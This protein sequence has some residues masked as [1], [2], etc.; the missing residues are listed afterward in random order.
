MRLIFMGTPDFADSI[1]ET[2]LDDNTFEVV[3]V[4]SQPP[5]PKGRGH[6]VTLS[7]V[8]EVAQKHNIPVL[9]PVCLKNKEEQELFDSYKADIAVVAAYGLLLPKEILQSP[10]KGCVNVHASLL[11]RFR[12]AAPIQRAILQGDT[13]TG[14]TFMKM[15]EGLDTGDM[16]LCKDIAITPTD[17][18]ATVHDKLKHLANDSIGFWLKEYFKGGL[19]P[20]FQPT[21][22]IT[23]A[24]KLSKTEAEVSFHEDASLIERKVRALSPWPGVWCTLNQERVKL[25]EV[26]VVDKNG[27]CGEIID[28]PLTVACQTKSLNIKVLQKENSKP[29][30]AKDY[31]N[32]LKGH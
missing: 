9:T 27:P 18:A 13:Q 2:L 25:L 28:A 11:P 6:K 14:I 4:Y 17:T 3:A 16:I 1:L 19:T 32:G 7:P 12:G 20:V 15:D 29:M 23:Y 10:L 8:H 30:S 5:R 24:S 21:Q 22:G 31:L 26:T